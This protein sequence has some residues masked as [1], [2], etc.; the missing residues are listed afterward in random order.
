MPSTRKS[1]RSSAKARANDHLAM[2]LPVDNGLGKVCTRYKCEKDG[3]EICSSDIR[4]ERLE[5][6]WVIES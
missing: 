5:C 2:W 3:E 4:T 1:S 6:F